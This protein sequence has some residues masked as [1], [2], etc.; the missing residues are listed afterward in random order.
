MSLSGSAQLKLYEL[1]EGHC[2]GPSRR[3]NATLGGSV[4]LRLWVGLWME[5]SLRKNGSRGPLQV[6]QLPKEESCPAQGQ[7]SS[8]RQAIQQ[9]DPCCSP[10]DRWRTWP[11]LPSTGNMQTN[12]NLLAD[13]IRS[14][15]NLDHSCERWSSSWRN[16]P[17]QVVLGLGINF[18][19]RATRRLAAQQLIWRPLVDARPTTSGRLEARSSCATR[20]TRINLAHEL[21]NL[22]GAGAGAGARAGVGAGAGPAIQPASHSSGF[23]WLD[24]SFARPIRPLQ[25]RRAPDAASPRPLMAALKTREGCISMAGRSQFAQLPSRALHCNHLARQ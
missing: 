17:K 18:M 20:G 6:G 12:C 4:R 14:L 24:I 1:E 11:R 2:L 15:I 22:A 21:V 5:L 10:A 3:E 13:Q 19:E 7:L 9:V 25:L 8:I 23:E 16:G